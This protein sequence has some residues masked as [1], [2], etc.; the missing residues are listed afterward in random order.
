[1][2]TIQGVSVSKIQRAFL[3]V[4]ETYRQN[5]GSLTRKR[6]KPITNPAYRL[7]KIPQMQTVLANNQ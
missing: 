1:M 4:A 5:F 3:E 7:P 6:M 2:Q